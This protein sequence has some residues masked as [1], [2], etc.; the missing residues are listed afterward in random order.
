MTKGA[1]EA[2]SSPEGNRAPRPTQDTAMRMTRF[3]QMALSADR[4]V[5]AERAR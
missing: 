3:D 5:E 1:G 2:P 4:R